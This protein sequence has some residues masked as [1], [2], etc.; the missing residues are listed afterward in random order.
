MDLIRDGKKK[1]GICGEM[2]DFTDSLGNKLYVGDIVVLVCKIPKFRIQNT[3]I[4]VKDSDTGRYEVMGLYGEA[5]NGFMNG[6]G[7]NIYRAIPYYEVPEGF[8]KDSHKYVRDKKE[9]TISEIEKE[10]GYPIKIVKEEK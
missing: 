9:M 1:S 2:V 5:E 10:L 3:N 6:S 7:W 4:I 8:V